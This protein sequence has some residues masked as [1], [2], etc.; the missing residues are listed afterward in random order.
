MQISSMLRFNSWKPCNVSNI[1]KSFGLT[2]TITNMS[3][4]MSQELNRAKQREQ[5]K[6]RKNEL[7][8]MITCARCPE[9]KLGVV[10]QLQNR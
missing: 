2:N 1:T 6:A 3:L 10:L 4:N 7:I 8:D 9:Q 5:S